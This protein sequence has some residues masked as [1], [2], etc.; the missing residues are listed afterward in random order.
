VTVLTTFKEDE[1]IELFGAGRKATVKKL[2]HMAVDSGVDG[3]VCSPRE[4]EMLRNNRKTE[5]AVIVLPAVRPGYA[6]NPDDQVN[7]TTPRMAREAGGDLLVVGRPLT[8]AHEYGLTRTEALNI[9]VDE[10]SEAT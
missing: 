5:D 3:L 2:A 7:A 10:V 8:D 4:A 6:I 9:I 1:C